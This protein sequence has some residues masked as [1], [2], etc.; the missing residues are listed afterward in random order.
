MSKVCEL[1][2][3]Q[4]INTSGYHP[5]TDGPVERF[6]RTLVEMLSKSS[7]AHPRDWDRHLP[8]VLYAYRTSIQSSTKESPFFLLYGRD[9]RLPTT[10]ALSHPVSPYTVDI[11]DYKHDIVT[12]LTEAWKLAKANIEGAQHIQKSHYDKSSRPIQLSVGDR[13]MVHTPSEQKG[14]EWKLVLS[15]PWAIPC[16]KPD[17]YQC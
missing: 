3:V 6:N 2:G 13:V 14:Q 12:G 1:L 8:F 5:Q 16:F 10:S 7:G 15:L 9:A 11:D 17:P 4:K